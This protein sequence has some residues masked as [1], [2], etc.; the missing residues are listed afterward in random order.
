MEC[1]VKR[2]RR[3]VRN[4]EQFPQ[5]VVCFITIVSGKDR[6]DREWPRSEKNGKQESVQGHKASHT[7]ARAGVRRRH[8]RS[9]SPWTKTKKALS[10]LYAWHDGFPTGGGYEESKRHVRACCLALR[11]WATV[12][13]RI[14]A[15]KASNA[16]SWPTNPL[17]GTVLSSRPSN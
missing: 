4:D 6:A 11:S 2:F 12:W 3:F 1:P 10:L 7:S 9:G 13:V 17:I 8:E 14:R 15:T 5:T 16:I